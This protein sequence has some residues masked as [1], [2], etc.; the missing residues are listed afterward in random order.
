MVLQRGE[1]QAQRTKAAII[2]ALC[3]LMREKHYQAITIQEIVDRANTGRSTLYRYFPS[4]ADIITQMHIDIFVRM[5]FAP[6]TAAEWLADE[7]PAQLVQLLARF[8]QSGASPFYFVAELGQDTDYVLRSIED[9]LAQSFEAS[10]HSAFCEAKSTMPFAVLARA[11]AG[12]YH[13]L[14]RYGTSASSHPAP[15]AMAA[16]IHRLSRATLLEAVGPGR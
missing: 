6:A 9:L 4:K 10:L 3:T 5:N 7:P 12:I 2:H 8:A 1:R 16:Y 15:A 13:W 14:A 11:I